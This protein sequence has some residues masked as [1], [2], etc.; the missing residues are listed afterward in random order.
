MN[1]FP[2][3]GSLEPVSRAVPPRRLGTFQELAS[4]GQL[5]TFSAVF[6]PLIPFW[7]VGNALGSVFDQPERGGGSVGTMAERHAAVF[8][9]D[10]TLVRGATGPTISAALRQVGLLSARTVPGEGLVFGLF[11]LIGENRAAM[12]L[13]RRGARLAAGWDQATAQQAGRLAAEALVEHIAPYARVLI[14]EHHAAGRQVVL[15]TTTP[16][17]MVAP[18]AAALGIDAVVAT[19]YE[20]RDGQYTG[21]IDG[22]FVW[23]K[24]KLRAVQRWAAEEGI[25]LAASWAYSDS[26][27]DVPLL[28]AVGHPVAVHADARLRAY[29]AVR[30]WLSVNLDVPPGVPKFLGLEP[31]QLLMPITR[32]QLLLYADVRVEGIE[33][34]PARGPAIMCANHRSYFDPV[35]LAFAVAERGRPMR[36][37]AKAE[38]F[39][40]PVIGDVVRAMGGIRVDRGDGGGDDHRDHRDGEAGGSGDRPSEPLREADAALAAGEMVAILPQ[41]TIPRGR[42]FFEPVLRGRSGAARL[43]AMSGAPVIPVAVWGTEHVWPRSEK[44]PRMWNVLRPPAVLVRIGEPVPLTGEDIDADTRRIMDAVVDLLPWE[45]KQRHDPTTEELA[46][47]YPGGIITD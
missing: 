2:P 43:A 45:A 1:S 8:D 33:N 14:D 27:Y 42:A 36:F 17:D 24:G 46:R 25:D 40:P 41:G 38:L 26:W 10:R 20:V 11:D 32:P 34:L 13:T 15:A 22:D 30:R 19:T 29:A 31:Q 16:H 39:A 5:L 3:R 4:P 21:R 47:T 9:L 12:E 7:L 35:A 28:S 37:L 44:V 6:S 18:L 23:G